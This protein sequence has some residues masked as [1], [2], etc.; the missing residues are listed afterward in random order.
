MYESVPHVNEKHRNKTLLWKGYDSEERFHRNVLDDRV[1]WA[2]S[3]NI[4]YQFNSYGFR[5]EEFRDADNLVSLGCSFTMGI[6]IP[7]ESSWSSIVSKK[8]NLANFNLAVDGS[9]AD[10]CFRLALNWIPQ[11]KPKIVLYQSPEISRLELFD[12]EQIHNILP[13]S[14]N[15]STFYKEWILN[16]NNL[17]YNHLKNLYAIQHLSESVGARFVHISLD[18]IKRF[19]CARDIGHYGPK[20]HSEV[21]KFVLESVNWRKR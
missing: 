18:N 6:G 16:E 4:D 21:A 3:K 7:Y 1:K 13:S 5:S 12:D 17:K 20:T 8:L 2:L 10:C 9:S 15:H 14:E 11:L 19:D